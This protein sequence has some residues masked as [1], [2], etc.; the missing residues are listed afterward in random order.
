MRKT[1]TP[2]LAEP[3]GIPKVKK[4]AAPQSFDVIRLVKIPRGAN[5]YPAAIFKGQ[6]PNAGTKITLN[7]TNGSV[8]VGTVREAVKTDGEIICEFRDG[9]TP[10]ATK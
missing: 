9:L 4:K 7:M 2:A 1:K 5:S 8:Y 6:V 3:T 10:V